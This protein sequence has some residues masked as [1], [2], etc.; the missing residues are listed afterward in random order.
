MS[1]H[2]KWST[3]KRKK[4]KSDVAK[5]KVFTKIGRELAVAIKEGGP[6][7]STNFKLRDVIAKAKIS[8]MPNE[9]ISRTIKKASGELGTINYEEIQYEGYGPGGVAV[10][11]DSLTDNKNRTASDVRHAFDK[12]GGSLGTTGCVAWM[13]DT[14][15]VILLTRKEGM[16]EDEVMMA[17]VDA[18]AED[19]SAEEDV[20]EVITDPT[21]LGSARE[22]LEGMGYAVESA[23]I[24]K[25]ART[26]VAPPKD[27]IEGIQN[28]LDA[29]EEN[30]DVQNVYH[31]A[32]IGEE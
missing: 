15:G 13:F 10:I 29:L 17:A 31:N 25:I 9:N 5:G 32:E 8:N 19:F 21:A 20:F 1:G 4:E 30:D 23:E 24:E 2:S 16:S 28:L 26:T 14:K 3:I 22:A 12:H 18:G 11:V 27:A 7:P 6:D